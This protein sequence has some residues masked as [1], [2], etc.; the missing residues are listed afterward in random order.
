MKPVTIQSYLDKRAREDTLLREAAVER[1]A[2]RANRDAAW[3]TVKSETAR[4]TR[5]EKD[6]WFRLR[7]TPEV[8]KRS[9]EARQTVADIPAPLGKALIAFV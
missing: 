1:V 6:D 5:A 7:R 2:A 3:E 4:M 9:G 8:K